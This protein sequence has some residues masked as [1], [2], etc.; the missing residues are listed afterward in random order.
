M[1]LSA[2]LWM[3]M[4]G[5]ESKMTCCMRCW[6]ANSA[7]QDGEFRL[8]GADGVVAGPGGTLG[9]V[10]QA[11]EVG[12]HQAGYGTLRHVAGKRHGLVGLVDAEDGAHDFRA[13][14]PDLHRQREQER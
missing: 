6:A 12:L 4:A 2:S 7:D 11:V 14:L 8:L 10:D 9:P 13:G 3:M 5:T 1:R